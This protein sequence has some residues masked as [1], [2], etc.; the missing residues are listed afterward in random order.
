VMIAAAGLAVAAAVA[1]N[2]IR[3]NHL[4]RPRRL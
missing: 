4:N 3:S 1:G 2:A